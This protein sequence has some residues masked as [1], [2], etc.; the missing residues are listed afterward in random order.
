MKIKNRAKFD[1]ETCNLSKL[2]NSRNKQSSRSR[3]TKPFEM[4]HTDVAGPIDPTGRDGFRY[5]II[6]T[7]AYSGCSFTYFLKK[8]SDTLDA[9]KKFFADISPNG[10]VQNI[11]FHEEI[12]LKA[13]NQKTDFL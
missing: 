8:K 9:I 1:C 7:D 12:I 3:P 2:T 6:F 10:K 4:V 5:A 11:D 13:D